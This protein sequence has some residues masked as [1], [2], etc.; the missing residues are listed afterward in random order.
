VP[1][2]RADYLAN[3]NH[4]RIV[5]FHAL[6]LHAKTL[7]SEARCTGPALRILIAF[8]ERLP[9]AHLVTINHYACVPD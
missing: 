7:E 1:L 6:P 9:S 4:H 5:R 8:M 2:I 3:A